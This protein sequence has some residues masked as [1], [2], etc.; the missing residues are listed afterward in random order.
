MEEK[1]NIAEEAMNNLVKAVLKNGDFEPI[2]R[3]KHEKS[4]YKTQWAWRL[5]CSCEL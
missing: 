5:I 1:R 3:L 4:I 2:S